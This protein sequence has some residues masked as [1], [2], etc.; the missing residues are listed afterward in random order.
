V[1]LLRI[2]NKKYVFYLENGE[3]DLL[4][5]ILGLYPVIPSAHQ[6]LSKSC[7]DTN[8]ESQ[9]LLDEA[10]AEQR[11]ENKTLVQT[12]LDDQKRFSQLKDSCRMT[13]TP[14]EI[15]WL[16]QILNDVRVGNWILLGSPGDEVWDLELNDESAPYLWAMHFAARFQTHLLEALHKEP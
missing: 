1:N 6:P 3:R 10:L 14:A 4:K 8:K 12:F 15:E 7:L 5:L 13:L 9:H 11:K 16:L 2:H